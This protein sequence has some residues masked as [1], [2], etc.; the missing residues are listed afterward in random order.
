MCWG[1]CT[2]AAAFELAYLK[3]PL[4]HLMYWKLWLERLCRHIFTLLEFAGHPDMLQ[5]FYLRCHHWSVLRKLCPQ[6]QRSNTK[7][8]WVKRQTLIIFLCFMQSVFHLYTHPIKQNFWFHGHD[9]VRP[10]QMFSAGSSS[11]VKKGSCC[12]V[13]VA[14]S[15]LRLCTRLICWWGHLCRLSHLLWTASAEPAQTKWILFE[16]VWLTCLK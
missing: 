9:F 11:A 13:L 14:A 8:I 15:F 12:H 16:L 5:C 1:G 6:G 4:H 3:L 2:P 7:I 10:G